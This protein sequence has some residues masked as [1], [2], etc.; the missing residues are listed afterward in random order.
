MNDNQNIYI[1]GLIDTILSTRYGFNEEFLKE[2]KG[3]I[4][5]IR[6]DIQSNIFFSTPKPYAIR[7]IELSLESLQSSAD[8]IKHSTLKETTI[9]DIEFVV[10]EIKE[11][12]DGYRVMVEMI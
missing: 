8:L 6:K 4:Q 5:I 2:L 3:S 9:K 7:W 12:L 10:D 1:I 11:L